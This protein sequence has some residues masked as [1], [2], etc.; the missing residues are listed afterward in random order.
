MSKH[1][2]QS[3]EPSAHEVEQ[4]V[5]TIHVPRGKSRARYVMT[6]GLLV[7]ILVIFVVS[8]LFQGMFARRGGGGSDGPFMEWNHPRLGQRS[9]GMRDW[10]LERR[11]VED[12]Y[13][14]LGVDRRQLRDLTGDENIARTLILDE[15]ALEAGVEFT[16]AELRALIKERFGDGATYKQILDTVQVAPADFQEVLRRMM[17]VQRYES[18]LSEL[19]AQPDAEQIEKSWKEQHKQHSLEVVTFPASSDDPEVALNL[20][21]EAGFAAW[22][23]ALDAVRKRQLF[24][25]QWKA[26]RVSA[27]LA[28]FAFE[29]GDATALI[30]R[31][32]RP[33]G[34]DPEQLAR[35]FHSQFAHLRFRRPEE[36]ADAADA[37]ERLYFTFDEVAERA[38]AEAQAHAALL[39]WSNDLRSRIAAGAE[40]DLAAEAVALGLSYSREA[41]P[42]S[43]LEWSAAQTLGGPTLSDS[44]MRASRGDR[45]I[46]ALVTEKQMVLGRV[47][48]RVEAGAPPY[49][50]VADAVVVEWRKDKAQELA[51]Q[52]AGKLVEACKPPLVDGVQAQPMANAEAFAVKAAELGAAVES[53]DW[54]DQSKLPVDVAEGE[55]HVQHFLRELKLGARSALN[56]IP[57]AVLGPYTAT[58]KARVFVAR[59][60]GSRDAPEVVIEP[61]EFR[62]LES[63]AR[64]ES[65]QKVSDELFGKAGLERNFGLRFPGRAEPEDAVPPIEGE[66]APAQQG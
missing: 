42:K 62:G 66:E 6:I 14:V 32:P 58:D 40:V 41:T 63:N 51:R 5:E 35:D 59:Y 17:R 48:E 16:D 30:A 22:Y 19:V 20:P 4:E 36:K 54:F 56:S 52:R 47:I 39:D 10:V 3:P 11:R 29:G 9:V 44:I 1:D 46:S 23:D 49:A 53:T 50:E 31:Y 61:R 24:Q 64:R 13:R 21:D 37:R 27:E 25:A 60:I 26:E 2:P 28:F 38:R 8:D 12:F 55:A 18:S 15:L 7:F 34:T 65:Q 43:Q 45:F 57:D 33:E